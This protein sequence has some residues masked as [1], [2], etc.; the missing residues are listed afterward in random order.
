MPVEERRRIALHRHATETWGEEAADTLLGISTPA[1]HD[2]ATMTDIER[3]LEHMDVRF[4]AVEQR[5]EAMEHRL[6]ALFERRVTDAVASQTRTLV[7]SQLA[8]L[9]TISALAFGLR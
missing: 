9:V 2:P 6:S 8:A 1:G 5:M 3:V 4:A 7:W